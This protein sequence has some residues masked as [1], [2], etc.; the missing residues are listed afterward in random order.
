MA[1]IQMG[2]NFKFSQIL[3]RLIL[4]VSASLIVLP[5]KKTLADTPRMYTYSSNLS[6]SYDQ[7]KDR[8]SYATSLVLSKMEEP[9]EDSGVFRLM[10]T[11]AATVASVYCIERPPN[12]TFIVFTSAY[13]TFDYSE[14]Q[15]VS[16]RIVQVMLGQK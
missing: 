15:S 1:N 13:W 9:Y 5:T 10:G 8:A 16:D 4:G 14:A 12:S 3:T 2:T 11:T 7:C 6:F